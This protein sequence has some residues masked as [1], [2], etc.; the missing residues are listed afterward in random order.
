MSITVLTSAFLLA[1]APVISDSNI[2]IEAALS[3]APDVIALNIEEQEIPAA[4]VE[5]Q[6]DVQ[7]SDPNIELADPV[8]STT[9]TGDVET[10]TTV[11]PVPEANETE[12]EIIVTGRISVPGDPFQ[13][14]N[15]ESYA[16]TQAV[17]KAV[18]APTANAY[19]KV[20]PEPVRNGLRNFANNLHEP[21]VFVNFLLQLKPGKA[22]ETAGRFLVNS[23]VGVAGLFDIA[24]RKPVNLPRR[25][26]GFADTMGCYGIKPGPFLFLPVIGATTVRDL[27]GGSLDAISIPNFAGNSLSQPAVAIP[28]SIARELDKR[29]EFDEELEIIRNS[30]DPYVAAR[31]YYLQKRQH[32]IEGLCG[33]NKRNVDR[34]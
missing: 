27:I 4:P 28:S 12:N 15:A 30:N 10:E 23:T 9:S 26:N 21:S 29:V 17:D 6:A 8:E 16:I 22:A 11:E 20:V 25:L 32:Q 24:K 33:K 19:E 31:E 18:V 13:N 34:K 5:S 2:P 14:I 3:A 7:A 1:S